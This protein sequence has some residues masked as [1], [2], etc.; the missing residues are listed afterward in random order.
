MNIYWHTVGLDAR[1]PVFGGLQ[2]DQRLF[3]RFLESILFKL[4]TSEI[5]IFYLV[6]VAVWTGLSLALLET[7]K[8]GFLAS[9]SNLS[10]AI[11]LQLR[12]SSICICSAQSRNRY[13]SRMA[14][15]KVRIPTW[16]RKVGILTLRRA[17]LEWSLR[18]VGIWTK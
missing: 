1:K 5:L 15:R 11:C 12:L 4:D 3:I 9:R 17:I 7:P 2:I 18:K 6:P 10:L 14:L 8:K 16:L 13:H